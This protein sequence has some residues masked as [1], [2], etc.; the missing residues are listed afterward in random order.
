MINKEITQSWLDLTL[1]EIINEYGEG[2]PLDGD[3][4]DRVC[5]IIKHKLNLFNG[6]I[7]QAEYDE[8]I[9]LKPTAEPQGEFVNDNQYQVFDVVCVPFVDDEGFSSTDIFDYDDN[10]LGEIYGQEVP[11]DDD[12]DTETLLSFEKIIKEWLI[13]GGYL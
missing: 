11:N 9:E 6:N 12:D 7:T 5:E 2:E 10:H 4:V 1:T 3:D 8:L 13:G